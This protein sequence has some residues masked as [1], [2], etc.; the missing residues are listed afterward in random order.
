MTELDTVK[1]A[2]MYM[3]KLSMGIDPLTDKP[4]PDGE[5]AVSPRMT[6]CF[7]YVTGLLEQ[8][9]ANGGTVGEERKETIS[10]EEAIALYEFPTYPIS[11]SEIIRKINTLADPSPFGKLRHRDAINWLIKIG[12]VEEEEGFDGKIRKFPS[13]DGNNL[14]ITT[15]IRVNTRQERYMVMLYDQDAQQFILDN[16]QAI[17]GER[18]ERI[19]AK[20]SKKANEGEPWTLQDEERLMEMYN[21]NMSIAKIAHALLR[22]QGAI[23]SRLKKIQEETE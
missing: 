9:V 4:I 7:Q 6:R 1:R 17:I 5:V 14:G 15:D 3:E 10:M 20:P 19:K 8:I 12:A 13:E 2:K 23:R 16:I 11:L 22:S 18:D 21:Q